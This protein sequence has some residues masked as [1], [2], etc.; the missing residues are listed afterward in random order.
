MQEFRKLCLGSSSSRSSSGAQSLDQLLERQWEQ[1]SQ[2]LMEQAQHFD[3]ASLLSC[4]HQLRSENVR[5]EEHVGSLLQRRDHLLAVNARLAIP[6][7]LHPMAV[8]A[9]PAES[10]GARGGRENGAPLRPPPPPRPET[11][12]AER[13]Q[14]TAP[15]D[16]HEPGARHERHQVTNYKLDYHGPVPNNSYISKIIA[17]LQAQLKRRGRGRRRGGGRR[18]GGG[19]GGA[20]G[21]GAL[22][23]VQSYIML[24]QRRRADF[25]IDA[26]LNEP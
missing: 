26:I 13:H 21:A 24:E 3:I 12:T 10:S 5:L 16:Y 15:L 1:G 19:G 14:V 8:S 18:G 4:L 23:T 6:L 25:S 2:F 7:T 9:A 22:S 17:N 20:G 11:V